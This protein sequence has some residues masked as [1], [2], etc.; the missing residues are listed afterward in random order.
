MS[1]GMPQ[2][3][4]LPLQPNP[5]KIKMPQVQKPAAFIFLAFMAGIA[6]ASDDNSHHNDNKN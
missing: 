6:V 2:P 1:A 4:P 5:N 3:A